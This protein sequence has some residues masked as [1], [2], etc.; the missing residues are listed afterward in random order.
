V[1]RQQ[2]E[3]SRLL[4][5]TI[6]RE[7][8]GNA[9][10]D[11]VRDEIVA[12]LDT[13]GGV[14]SAEEVAE[15]LIVARG[16]YTAE[17][18][19]TTQ[20]IGLVRAATETE[21]ARGGDAR[22]AMQRLR[23]SDTVLLGREPADPTAERTAADL[24]G[25]VVRLGR[26]AA[27][28]AGTDPL[29]SRARAVEE[30]RALEP[31]P[32]GMPPVGD[33]RLLQLAAAGSGGEAAVNAQGQLYPA[34]M[35]AERAL[36]LAAGA[37][38][39]QILDPETVR[40]RVRTRF[41]RAEELPDRPALDALLRDIPLTWHPAKGQFLPPER[42]SSISGTRMHTSYGPILD[43][44]AATQTRDRLTGA[45][46][47]GGFLVLLAPIKRL[48]AARRALLTRLELVEVDITAIMLGRLRALG[49]PWEALVSAD[50]GNPNDADFRSLS[51]LVRHEV[52]PA[53]EQTLAETT[54]PVLITEAA[55]LARYQ[56]LR[57][58]QELADPT[59]PRPAARLLLVPARRTE[60]VLL[61]GVQ[62]PLTAPASQ[63]LWLPE[64][65]TTDSSPVTTER[66]T[67]A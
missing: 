48:G 13:R 63:S 50:N 61:D 60:P 41:P 21:L 5:R 38:V 58:I 47:R 62:L 54:E 34:G 17:P 37:L 27:V 66:T 16:S 55:P 65:W 28:L 24:L 4:R 7:W 59:R 22:L 33:A 30:L 12:L 52:L 9:G 10:L 42:L 35:P 64:Q 1:G 67:R 57:L 44:G 6:D 15:A 19:R 32:A 26:R 20:A 53:I 18:Q 40:V 3:V 29:P 49:F 11:A 46:D 2:P 31:P 36:R 25:Y 14:M 39:G 43:L 8:Q 51:E 56:Q 45:I 23:G